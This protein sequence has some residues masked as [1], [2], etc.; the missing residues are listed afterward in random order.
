M[1]NV[2]ECV[3]W[4]KDVLSS[5]G[6]DM[7]GEPQVV[8]EVPWSQVYCLET[9]KGRV[10]LK[11]MDSEF[12]F[13]PVLLKYLRDNVTQNVTDVIASNEQLSCFLMRDAGEPL[14]PIL[15]ADCNQELFSRALTLYAGI[16]ISCIQHV[17]QLISLGIN[18]WRL[19]KIPRFF[20]AFLTQKE[21]LLTD[22]LLEPEI[23]TLQQLTPAVTSLCK[24]LQTYGI[25]ETIEHCDFHDNNILIRDSVMTINDWG[26]ACISH[27]FFSCVSALESAKRNHKVRDEELEPA[28]RKYLE[29]WKSYGT[30]ADL[31]EAF[32]LAR[33]IRYFT[34]ALSFSRIKSCPGIDRYPQF[35]GYI[36]EALRD[37]I[38]SAK[39]IY[40]HLFGGEES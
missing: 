38:K 15:K 1:S 13:E 3:T 39:Q 35:N 29:K 34:F 5:L 18:D 7:Q 31:H 26:D 4:G 32:K 33:T 19:D 6:Y 36:A 22:G 2:D 14:R 12:A 30:Q 25:P 8:R 24:K 27:P 16:Q 20:E 28:L 21:M 10:F 40:I 17:E 9:S 37:I 11:Y 23:E